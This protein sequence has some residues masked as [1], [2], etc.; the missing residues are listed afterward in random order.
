MKMNFREKFA[1]KPG[2]RVKLTKIDPDNTLDFQ[3]KR[4]HWRQSTKTK[5]I[6]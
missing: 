1:V 5:E 2:S 3:I 4:L 6:V